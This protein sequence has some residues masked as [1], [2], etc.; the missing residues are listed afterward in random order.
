MFFALAL[1]IAAEVNPAPVG[2]AWVRAENDGAGSGFVVDTSERLLIT[3]RHVVSDRKKVDVFFP[4]VRDGALVTDR[5]EYLRNR[6]T[7]RTAKLLVTG[8]IR[9]TADELDLALV[10]LDELPPGTSAVTF[11]PAPQ[12]GDPLRVV[13]HRLDLDTVW[14]LTSGPLRVSGTLADGYFWRGKKLA[15]NAPVL[16]GQLPIE[17]G[18]SGGPVYNSRGEVVG[19]ACALRRQCPLAAVCISGAAIR[20][21]V[22]AKEPPAP[23]PALLAELLV[24]GTV[25]VKPTTTDVHIA[26][27]LIEKDLVLTCA[28][29]L[30]GTDRVGVLLPLR[31]GE[32]QEGGPEGNPRGVPP[33]RW[34]SERSAYRDPLALYLR[35]AWRTGTVLARDP[36][37]DLALVRLDSGGEWMKP[38]PLAGAVPKVGDELHAMSHPGGL[39]FAWVY[40]GGAVRQRGALALNVG[41][42][43]PA[44]AVLVCQLPAQT[45]SPGGP[46]LNADGELVGVLSAREGA[47]LVGYAATTD[48]IRTFLDVALRDRPARTLAGLLARVE[49][50]PEVYGTGLARG[51]AGRAEEHRRAGRLAEARRDCAAAVALASGCAVARLCG[52]RLLSPDDALP[53]LDV[54]V[55]KGPFH[56]DVLVLRA[57]L[58]AQVKDWKKARGDLE[59]VLDVF[60]AD[61]DARQRL[62]GVQFGLGEDAKAATAIADTLRADPKRLAA[63]AVDLLAQADTLEQKFPDSPGIA[64]DWLMKALVA[65]SRGTPDAKSRAVLASVLASAREAKTDVDRLRALRTGVKGLR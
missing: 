10:Q 8:T 2:C 47:Q 16:I 28:R 49:E 32:K 18:D 17:E 57:E 43:A 41:E 27:V 4:W 15:Q 36:D 34:I 51:L 44:V 29:G 60:P 62:A 63:V 14:N 40:A 9:K 52:A 6:D 58:A 1:F 24:R 55:E 13:G 20:A 45:G 11:G 22:S 33:K 31:E 56:R 23:K 21:F 42:R 5:R 12:P 54:A 35:G 38:I 25:W 64:A 59:R 19:M 65:A 53:E 39:E 26:G 48:E 37:R 50:L 30:S 46:V 61:A 3:C 7:L